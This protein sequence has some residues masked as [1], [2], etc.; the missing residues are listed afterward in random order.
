MRECE[1]VSVC[2]RVFGMWAKQHNR[3]GRIFMVCA[4]VCVCVYVCAYACVCVCVC[5][6]ETERVCVSERERVYVSERAREC[7]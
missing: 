5:V 3:F 4:S 6:S 1:R 2:V 7:V